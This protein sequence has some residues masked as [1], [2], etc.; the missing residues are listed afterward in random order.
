MRVPSPRQARCVLDSRLDELDR[1]AEL[2]AAFCRDIGREAQTAAFNLCAEEIVTNVVLHGYAG[3]PG[4]PIAV[5][6]RADADRISCRVI[7]E[8]IAF[9]PTAEPDADL[10][11]VLEDR[12]IGGLGRHLVSTMMDEFR[13]CRDDGRNV[14][15]FG[16]TAGR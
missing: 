14:V 1:L 5:E 16:R 3:E 4:H 15:V 7:D 2:V 12:P 9:D 6:L 8:G 13:Y 10:T 11:S